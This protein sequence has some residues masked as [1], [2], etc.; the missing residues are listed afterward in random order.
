MP[1][2]LCVCP[3]RRV[4]LT[5]GT[6]FVATVSVD[7]SVLSAAADQTPFECVTERP[8]KVAG[9][10]TQSATDRLLSELDE[11]ESPPR[12]AKMGPQ[13]VAHAQYR[14][15]P[16]D[17]LTTAPGKIRLGVAFAGSPDQEWQNEVIARARRWVANGTNLSSKVELSFINSIADAQIVVGRAGRGGLP[18]AN[19]SLIGRLAL[20]NKLEDGISTM[21]IHDMSSTEHEFGHALCLG[22]E[23]KHEA[24]PVKIDRNKA[25]AYFKRKYDWPA[26][27]TIDNVLTSEDRCSGDLAFNPESC[28]IYPIPPEILEEPN[29]EYFRYL[30]IHARD[31]KCLD[32]IYGA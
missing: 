21:V 31:R 11:M 27:R 10:S 14:W 17:G 29:F 4:V 20:S 32:D 26:Q 3:S 6:A 7:T 16:R 15:K 22:H 2:N 28:M 18:I 8:R 5:A 25:I 24:L 13:G 19:K 23:H 9:L 12:I 30:S 1:K